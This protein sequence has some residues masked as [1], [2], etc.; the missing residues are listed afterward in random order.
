MSDLDF[1]EM[2]LGEIGHAI[3]ERLEAAYDDAI[4]QGR[5]EELQRQLAEAGDDPRTRMLIF[6][7]FGR[8]DAA[9]IEV[10]RAYPGADALSRLNVAQARALIYRDAE[11]WGEALS[12]LTHAIGILNECPMNQ[13]GC[14]SERA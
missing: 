8:T 13:A 10:A 14:C 3:E 12:E 1:T 9:L 5:E 7:R 11:R 2:T 6:S 4:A